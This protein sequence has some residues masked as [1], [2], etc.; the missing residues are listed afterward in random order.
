VLAE[1]EAAFPEDTVIA[2]FRALTELAAGS[3]KKATRVLL[4]G[5]LRSSNPQVDFYRR[6]LTHYARELAGEP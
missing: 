6:A 5:V 1:G 2:A 3:P 4:D